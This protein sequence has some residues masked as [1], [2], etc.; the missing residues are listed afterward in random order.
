MTPYVR[1]V[2]LGRLRPSEHT[3]VPEGTG[4]DKRPVRAI[5]VRDPGPRDGGLGS[6]VVGDAIGDRR[7]HGGDRQAVYAFAR[8]ELD[9]WAAALGRELPDGMFGEN[10]TTAAIDV[11]A[12]VVGQRWRVGTAVL[13]VTGPRI[14]CRTFAG[15]MGESGWLRRFGERGRTGAYLAVVEAGTIERGAPIETGPPPAHGI[16][17]PEVFAAFMGDLELARRVVA[18]RILGVRDQ[19]SLA[20]RLRRA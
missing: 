15:H 20:K 10:L 6:G 1:S 13:E 17:V 8:E 3:S 4:I 14:P 2:N 11:D 5:D 9:W 16:V 19:K 7:H 12:A 18:A